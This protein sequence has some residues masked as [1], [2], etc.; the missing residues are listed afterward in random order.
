M[1]WVD[2][3]KRE[4]AMYEIKPCPKC[5]GKAE[6]CGDRTCGFESYWVQCSKCGYKSKWTVGIRYAIRDWNEAV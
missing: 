6:A 1:S 5:G 4:A 2:D 3:S